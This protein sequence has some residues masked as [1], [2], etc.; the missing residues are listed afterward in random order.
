MPNEQSATDTLSTESISSEIE[1]GLVV[2]EDVII[3]EVSDERTEEQYNKIEIEN[4]ELRFFSSTT[5]SIREID[6]EEIE[7]IIYTIEIENTVEI[8][9]ESTVY[10]ISGPSFTLTAL[11]INMN[12][13]ITEWIKEQEITVETEKEILNRLICWEYNQYLLGEY[14]TEYSILEKILNLENKEEAKE[15]LKMLIMIESEKLIESMCEHIEEIAALFNLNYASTEGIEKYTEDPLISRSKAL[16]WIKASMHGLLCGDYKAV[17]LS[18]M[19][20]KA[21]EDIILN[22]TAQTKID[23]LSITDLNSLLSQ[24]SIGRNNSSH[25][26]V[27]LGI[28]KILSMLTRVEEIEEIHSLYI[29]F[30]KAEEETLSELKNNQEMIQQIFLQYNYFIETEQYDKVLFLEGIINRIL[31]ADTLWTDSQLAKE[32]RMLFEEEGEPQIIEITEK[33][34]AVRTEHILTSFHLRIILALFSKN[35][36]PIAFRIYIYTSGLIDSLV[37]YFKRL[38]LQP[39]IV[40][41]G[42]IL[43]E[44]VSN[45]NKT[46]QK[47]ITEIQLRPEVAKS[48]ERLQK[49][50]EAQT[51]EGTSTGASIF[52]DKLHTTL[53]S[54]EAFTI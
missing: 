28:D 54:L 8:L 23:K 31:S 22:L 37:R 27:Y 47:Y 49:R 19:I 38:S 12:R 44:I 33:W 6:L 25:I 14:I 53:V 1:K 48:I 17:F 16:Q 43:L 10:T 13:V 45:K 34:R 52:L 46:L 21:Q 4:R 18:G 39:E 24:L 9:T 29:L 2:L 50:P 35:T 40:L 3:T 15:I 11:Q 20:K 36:I 26:I 5:E 30:T 32:I 41:V 51:P 7:E 42:Q